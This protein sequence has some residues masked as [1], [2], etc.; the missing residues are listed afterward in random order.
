MIDLKRGLIIHRKTKRVT[1]AYHIVSYNKGHF[2]LSACFHPDQEV[3]VVYIYV[4]PFSAIGTSS[5]SNYDQKSVVFCCSKNSISP[6][7][8]TVSLVCCV[9]LKSGKAVCPPCR[10]GLMIH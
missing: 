1:P 10:T 9:G 2:C 7:G 4:N 5:H 8:V 6:R 3:S